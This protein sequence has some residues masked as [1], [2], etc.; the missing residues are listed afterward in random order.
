MRGEGVGRMRLV[1]ELICDA[2]HARRPRGT[3]TTGRVGTSPPQAS[4]ASLGG[5]IGPSVT[6]PFRPHPG[7]R[8]H[9][10]LAVVIALPAWGLRALRGLP[11]PGPPGHAHAPQWWLSSLQVTQAWRSVRRRR[12]HRR[13][14]RHRGRHPL[15]GLVRCGDHRARR[16]RHR[17]RGTRAGRPVLG[18]RG[19]RG[20]RSHRW[21]RVPRPLTPCR[22]AP[23]AK[24]LSVRVTLEFN[25]PLAADQAVSRLLPAAIAAGIR[26]AASHGARII[27]LPLDPV[28]SG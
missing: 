28:R 1:V 6:P 27:D 22:V 17:R 9:W 18:C 23:R 4:P 2:F 20:G 3:I 19:H 26:Y 15:P 10:G 12:D 5:E 14:A 8:S 13:R 24:I 7:A 16:N 25:D 21:S 11:R